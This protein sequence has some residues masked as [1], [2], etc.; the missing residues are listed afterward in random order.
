MLDQTVP[1]DLPSDLTTVS[2][3]GISFAVLKSLM[4]NKLMSNWGRLVPDHVHP[5]RHHHP[6]H[7]RGHDH[8]LG[9]DD[10]VV[11]SVAVL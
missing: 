7:D 11:G 8:R 10:L 9:R 2:S 1:P 3:G 6:D 5:G 4:Q